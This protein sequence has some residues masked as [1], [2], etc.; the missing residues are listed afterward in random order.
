MKFRKIAKN[1]KKNKF[2]RPYFFWQCNRNHTSF[3]RPRPNIGKNGF[4]ETDKGETGIGE[5]E[6]GESARRLRYYC[7]PRN[8]IWQRENLQNGYRHNWFRRSRIRR[9]ANRRNGNR[10][11]GDR[12]NNIQSSNRDSAE[13]E[14]AIPK[15]AKRG[16]AKRESVKWEVIK[17]DSW[18]VPALHNYT[19]I[20][21]RFLARSIAAC[22]LKNQ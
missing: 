20:A 2:P 8:G 6:S 13:L 4:G 11:I 17:R 12:R 14:S 10:I 16:S 19:A 18:N 22:Q 5:T 1:E 15:S 7:I 3:F 9:T 21:N